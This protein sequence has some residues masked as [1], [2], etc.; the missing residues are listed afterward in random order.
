[1]NLGHNPQ[2]SQDSNP[3]IELP[4]PFKEL[5]ASVDDMAK[6]HPEAIEDDKLCYEIFLKNE[7]G[8]RL[9]E[10]WEKT[11]LMSGVSDPTHPQAAQIALHAAAIKTFIIKIKSHAFNHKMRIEAP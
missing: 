1:M 3:L 8:M 10:K 6:M 9:M 5:Q 4:N 2:Y 7:F 11:I